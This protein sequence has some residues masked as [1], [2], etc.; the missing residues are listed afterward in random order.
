MLGTSVANAG[1]ST[2]TLTS[3]GEGGGN[4]KTLS[5]KAGA[6]AWTFR[7][8]F[9]P[10]N[11]ARRLFIDLIL[12]GVDVYSLHICTDQQVDAGLCYLSQGKNNC[13]FVTP[14][15]TGLPDFTSSPAVPCSNAVHYDITGTQ[16]I[17][18]S[19]SLQAGTYSVQVILSDLVDS[20]GILSSVTITI[21]SP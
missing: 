5:Q 10:D 6:G 13:L 2:I 15:S 18:Q 14:G 7:I 8:D 21:T 4:G 1:L 19:P 17:V 16:A 12:K 11:S 9:T 3:T 20:A